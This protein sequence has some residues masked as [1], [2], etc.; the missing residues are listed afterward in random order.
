MECS[1]KLID[2]LQLRITLFVNMQSVLFVCLGN[3]CRSPLAEALFLEHV[4]VK[5][6]TE[7]FIADSAGTAA[8]HLGEL[9]DK[10]TRSMAMKLSNLNLTHKAR[11]FKSNDFFDFDFI[12][13]M[14]KT[15]FQNIM[16]L[17][18][19]NAKAKVLLMRHYD[20]MIQNEDAIPDP[21]YGNENDFERVHHMLNDCTKNFLKE[22]IG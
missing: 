6:L 14:D 8:Y 7:K 4:K 18:P 15:N 20:S 22:L 9:A 19:A 17:K 2:C 13:A 12:V 3:I 16:Q 21:Y 5:N 11:Q 10:R 1:A